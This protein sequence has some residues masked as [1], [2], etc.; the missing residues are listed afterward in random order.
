MNQQPTN[1]ARASAALRTRHVFVTRLEIDTLIGVYEHEKRETQKLIVSLDMTVSETTDEIDD[2]LDH[3][4]CYGDAVRTVERICRDG[5]VQLLET[6]ADNIAD[7]L[8]ADRRVLAVKVRLEKPDAFEHCEA[9]GI[10]IE[11]VQIGR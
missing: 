1:L 5:H 9:V 10:E 4:V 2:Q 7:A 8:L 11:R 3:V 6:M